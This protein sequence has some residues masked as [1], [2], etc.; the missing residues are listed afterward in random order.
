[1]P[2]SLQLPVGGRCFHQSPAQATRHHRCCQPIAR[3][4]TLES[5]APTAPDYGQLN[6]FKQ[7]VV[8]EWTERAETYDETDTYHDGMARQLVASANIQPGQ[9]VLDVATGTG[10]AAFAAA[11]AVGPTGRVFGIDLTHAMLSEVWQGP[12]V[13]GLCSWSQC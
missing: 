2:I 3:A 5:S 13:S 7:Q 10:L 4:A 1:M 8:Q 12:K 11:Q 6:E 9:T